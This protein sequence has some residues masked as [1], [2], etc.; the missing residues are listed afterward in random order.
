MFT[1][2]GVHHNLPRILTGN[3]VRV[4]IRGDFR[5][6]LQREADVIEAVQQTIAAKRLDFERN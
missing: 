3:S 4:L 6:V 5:F 1:R 2:I